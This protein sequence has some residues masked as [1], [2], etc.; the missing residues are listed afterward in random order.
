MRYISE[1]KLDEIIEESGIEADV[2]TEY[3][4]RAMYGRSCLGLVVSSSREM[5]KF[6]IAAG[7][8]LD[9]VQAYQLAAVLHQ[10]NMGLGWVFYFPGWQ[11]GEEEDEEKNES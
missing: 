8:V 9:E 2:R 6:F 5:F 10:D 11:V 1:E 3:S 4:G 7:H